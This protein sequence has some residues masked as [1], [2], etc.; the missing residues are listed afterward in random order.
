MFF[1]KGTKEKE[2]NEPQKYHLGSA[3]NYHKISIFVVVRV[4]LQQ[5]YRRKGHTT[6]NFSKEMERKCNQ[7]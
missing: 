1:I 5:E 4:H 7:C 6:E 2:K 3:K